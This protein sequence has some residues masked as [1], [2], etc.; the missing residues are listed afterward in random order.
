[1]V[2]GDGCRMMQIADLGLPDALRITAVERNTTGETNDV[3]FCS[4]EFEGRPFSAYIKVGKG[5]SSSLANERAVLDRLASTAIPTPRVLWYGSAPREVLVLEA[6]P[7]LILWDHIDPRRRLFD[8]DR[9]LNCLH[10]YGEC[11]GQ[12]HELTLDWAP[13]RRPRLYGLIGEEEVED[14]RF[15]RLVSWL[16]TDAPACD[17]RTFVHG[18]FNTASVLFHEGRI[19]GVI[20]WEY[21]GSGWREYDLAWV[22]R[23]RTSFLNTRAERDAILRGYRSHASY[24]TEALRHC[25]VLNYLHFAYWSKD[26]EPDYTSFALQQ[27]LDLAG[28]L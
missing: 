8:K 14:V 10:A 18:D 21:A 28:L 5:S 3:F 13:Q 22:L 19:S 27:A 20:D 25:E 17:H 2:T 9:V 23:A 24:G 16:H 7:G 26:A 11:L 4:G 1:M 15:Q 12:V 6:L